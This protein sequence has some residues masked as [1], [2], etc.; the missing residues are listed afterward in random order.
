MSAIGDKIFF[1]TQ[2]DRVIITPSEAYQKPY[3]ILLNNIIEFYKK[4][5]NNDI[6]PA[7]FQVH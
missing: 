3:N 4:E 6:V 2:G 5:L 1:M 7:E